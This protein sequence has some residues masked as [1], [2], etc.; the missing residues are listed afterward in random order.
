MGQVALGLVMHNHQPIGN[1]GWVNEEQYQKAYE[2]L[3]ACLER[4]PGVKL[5][6]HY[7]GSLLDWLAEAHPDFLERV[8]ALVERGQVEIVGGGFYEPVLAVL[9]EADRV[10]QLTALADAVE[11]RFGVRPEGMWLAERVWEPGL[12]HSLAEAGMRWTVVDDTHL[13]ASGFSGEDLH[14]YHLTEDDGR[15]VA[16]FASLYELR[17]TLLWQP[18]EETMAFLRGMAN[19]AAP[20]TLP[21]AVMGDDGEKF[22]GWPETYRVCY[23]EGYM[24]AFFAAIE[25]AAGWLVPVHLSQYRRDH[26]ALGRVYLPTAS[27]V[28]M[29]EWV[30]PAPASAAFGQL[31]AEMEV[32]RPD[33][34]RWL[35]GGFWRGFMTK[36]PEVNRLHKRMLRTHAK[37][38]AARALPDATG[39]GGLRDLYRGQNNDVYWHGVFGGIYMNHMRCET[40]R[41]LLLAEN[42]ADAALHADDH[43]WC[44]PELRDFDADGADELLVAGAHQNLLIDPAEGG[45]V[46]AWD[47]RRAAL[48]AFDTLA[49]RPEAYHEKIRAAVRERGGANSAWK[50]EENVHAVRLQEPNLDDYLAYDAYDRAGGIEHIL[51]PLTTADDFRHGRFTERGDFTRGTFTLDPITPDTAAFPPG[52]PE[53]GTEAWHFTL[54]RDGAITWA[55]GGTS[56]L[57][58][59]KTYT[60]QTLTAAFACHYCVTNG[61]PQA[62]EFVFASEWN[63]NL[64][65]GGHNDQCYTWMP[66][67]HVLSPLHDLPEQFMAATDLH[68]GN[69][70][71]DTDL[72]LILSPAA[73]LWKLPI[74]TVSNSV[75]GFERVYQGTSLIARWPLRLEPGATWEGSVFWT[76]GMAQ[77][78]Q[79]PL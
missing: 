57:T 33:L 76:A 25:E 52:A 47:V 41:R 11:E 53:G 62:V 70:Y 66:D 16:L 59:E 23:E 14:G 63:V 5:G 24:D 34:T 3:V 2:P 17:Y 30:L 48:N 22:G 49:R 46:Q 43:D 73:D 10:G 78:A 35:R 40:T 65:G 54:R 12:P 77:P 4:H 31:R 42:A 27:Y 21:L 51:D 1:F 56:P 6:L 8:R 58:I 67:H 75:D 60:A 32:A 69:T 50:A 13:F 71:L 72:Y 7:T 79:P 19:A 29:S 36:Y 18:L 20:G 74:E 15:P 38:H 68:M 55:D 45:A 9:P 37:V 64:Q 26:P 28:E 44:Q 61:G 39:D